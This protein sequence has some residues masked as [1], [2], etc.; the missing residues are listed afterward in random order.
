[1]F[2]IPDHVDVDQLS[3][4]EIPL[5]SL[6]K[7]RPNSQFLDVLSLSTRNLVILVLDPSTQEKSVFKVAPVGG[8]LLSEVM[9]LSQVSHPNIVALKNWWSDQSFV[10]VELEY[11]RGKCLIDMIVEQGKLSESRC[12]LILQQ[13][14]SAISYL[15][16]RGW[17]HRDLKPD[18]IV[19]DPQ[20]GQIKLIDFELSTRFQKGTRLSQ[21]SGT[22]HYL[23]PEVRRQNYEG[24]ESDAWSLGVTLYVLLTAHFPYSNDD[25]WAHTEYLKELHLPNCSEGIHDLIRQLLKQDTQSRMKIEFVMFHKWMREREEK[26]VKLN[27]PTKAVERVVERFKKIKH[28]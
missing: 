20:T 4:W 2:Q 6:F 17:V 1:M 13:L 9:C 11:V 25:L 28:N 16:S 21:R 19:F 7:L 3:Y 14:L 10:Y 18:N 23:S 5:R 8:C 15:H 22:I 26:N 27:D 12:R 24:P